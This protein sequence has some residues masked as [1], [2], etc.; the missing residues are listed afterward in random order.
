MWICLW[1]NLILF[2][3]MRSCCNSW[4]LVLFVEFHRL[5]VN[6]RR[7]FLMSCLCFFFL[8]ANKAP[9]SIFLSFHFYRSPLIV[10]ERV[11][12]DIHPEDKVGPYIMLAIDEHGQPTS[13]S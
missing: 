3:A 1:S 12:L 11:L 2:K 7:T 5:M 9:T 4:L 6:Q 13:M 10:T 8:A